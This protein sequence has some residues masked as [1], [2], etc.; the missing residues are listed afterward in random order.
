ML[1]T[2]VIISNCVYKIIVYSRC[3]CDCNK[4]NDISIKIT[5]NIIQCVLIMPLIL[6]TG[7]YSPFIVL[8]HA[9]DSH[10]VLSV[11]RFRM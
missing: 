8:V 4:Y 1:I 5:E 10:H 2:I 7:L 9:D 11:V 6:S 3:V